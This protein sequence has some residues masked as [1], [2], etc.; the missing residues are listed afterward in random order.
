LV[1]VHVFKQD[2]RELKEIEPQFAALI[3]VE[4]VLG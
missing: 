2:R 3:T 1:E 4:T